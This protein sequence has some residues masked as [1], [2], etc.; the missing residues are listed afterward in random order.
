[1]VV[2]DELAKF[3]SFS[4]Q[5]VNKIA[6]QLKGLLK[7]G[8]NM[9]GQL[10][11]QDRSTDQYLKSFSWNAMK[12]RSDRSIQEIGNTLQQESV[13]IDTLVK[14]KTSQYSQ[15]KGQVVSAERKQTGNLLVKGLSDIVKK[16][17][18][19]MDSEYLETLLVVVPT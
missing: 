13:Q 19:V 8:E 10:S 5:L 18:F 17:H 9:A 7:D 1:M 12:Y 16:E 2:S 3:D 11:V 4:D 6:S 14:N 15:L